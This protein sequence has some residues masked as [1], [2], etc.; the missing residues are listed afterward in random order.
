M[1]ACCATPLLEDKQKDLNSAYEFFTNKST[2]FVYGPAVAVHTLFSNNS[3]LL[4]IL[5]EWQVAVF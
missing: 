4:P 1:K 5:I 2:V 3:Y